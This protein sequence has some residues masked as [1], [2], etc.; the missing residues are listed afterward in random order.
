[1]KTTKRTTE[2][3]K[4]NNEDKKEEKKKRKQSQKPKLNIL[5]LMDNNGLGALEGIFKDVNFK[6]KGY[7]Y[8]DLKLIMRKMEIW[9]HQLYPS[10]Q[11]DDCLA[12]LEKLGHNK[13]VSTYVRKI[14]MGLE[15]EIS[16]DEVI[17]MEDDDEDDNKHNQ[18]C[19]S[20]STDAFDQLIGSQE[21]TT[22][23]STG[24]P[25]GLTTEQRERMLRNRLI[26]EQRRMEK[27]KA[28]QQ[29]NNSINYK[30]VINPVSQVDN[31]QQEAQQN[32][33]SSCE[34]PT[35]I[36][37]SNESNLQLCAEEINKDVSL[38]VIETDKSIS[39]TCDCTIKDNQIQNNT[40]HDNAIQNENINYKTPEIVKNVHSEVQSSHSDLNS[41]T[42]M[43]N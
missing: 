32:D 39:E 5:K 30:T 1:M 31:V 27:M 12:K 25:S 43:N 33:S 7:E 37:V 24:E 34:F 36:T 3:N 28:Q 10:L 42:E 11:F 8:E 9:A 21:K 2:E 13:S 38:S 40:S 4:E 17:D 14:R 19:P 6:G 29:Q 15:V 16:R 18:L 20:S 41:F 35:N 23:A 22:H 26:A